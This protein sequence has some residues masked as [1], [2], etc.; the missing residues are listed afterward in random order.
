M[1]RR[2]P[3][4]RCRLHNAQRQ[5]L[6]ARAGC[7]AAAAGG[8][9]RARHVLHAHIRLFRHLSHCKAMRGNMQSVGGPSYRPGEARKS[10]S[11]DAQQCLMPALAPPPAT[12]PA[13]R[14]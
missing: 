14:T 1:P 10:A 9:L 7:T 8:I 6:A 2:Q 4:R 11:S 13:G 5:R 3:R 12:A